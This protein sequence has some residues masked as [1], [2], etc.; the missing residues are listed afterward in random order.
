MT[1]SVDA[2]L[3]LQQY[4]GLESGPFLAWDAVNAPMIRHWCEVMGDRNPAYL[5]AVAARDAGHDGLVAP[6]TMLQVWGMAGYGGEHA[7]GSAK[8]GQFAVRKV[9]VA[10]GYTGVV[11]VNCEQKYLRYLQEGDRVY[12]RSRCESI[13]ELKTTALGE[14]Y[15]LEELSTYYNQRDEIV[16]TMSFRLLVYKSGEQAGE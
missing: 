4:V 13:S 6:P 3:N 2:E 14:G 1:V 5:D 8:S 7:P 9:L 12:F 16:G 11:A 15:F 10:A